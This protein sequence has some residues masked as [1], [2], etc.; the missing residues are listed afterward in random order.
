[1]HEN[2][3]EHGK[4]V[5]DSEKAPFGHTDAQPLASV[6]PEAGTTS[7][8]DVSDEQIKAASEALHSFE[9]LDAPVFPPANVG[10]ANDEEPPHLLASQEEDTETEATG[11][12]QAVGA[13]RSFVKAKPLLGLVAAV[14]LGVVFVHA[15][16]ARGDAQADA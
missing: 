15:V 11:A 7:A 5:L 12:K 9:N 4:P 3:D 14:A 10:M 2:N 13:I 6:F 8:V 1:M 16:R